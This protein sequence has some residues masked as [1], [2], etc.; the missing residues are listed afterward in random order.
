MPISYVIE[1]KAPFVTPFVSQFVSP[2]V[3]LA[4][5]IRSQQKGDFA[6]LRRASTA[7]TPSQRSPRRG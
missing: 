7:S 4:P 3:S 2:F 1:S 5:R 6:A